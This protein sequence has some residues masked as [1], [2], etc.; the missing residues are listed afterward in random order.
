MEKEY[1]ELGCQ[2][3]NPHGDC[4]FKVRA[5]TE[6]EVLRLGAEHARHAHSAETLPPDLAAKVKAAILS[7]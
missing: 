4:A 6:E 3:V 1:K 2:D 5:A 7:V